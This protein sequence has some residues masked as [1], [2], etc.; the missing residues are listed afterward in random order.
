MEY[1]EQYFKRNANKKVMIIWMLMGVALSIS[2]GI[3]VKKGVRDIPYFVMFLAACWVPFAIGFINTR[4]KGMANESYKYISAIGY[5]FFYAFVML[6]TINPL[7]F[8][9]IF[10]FTTALM[11]YKDKKLMIGSGIANA[12]IIISSVVN[13]VVTGEATGDVFANILIQI[14][15]I[16]FCCVAYVMSTEH[17]L[18]SD[19][20][21]LHTVET[22]L[23]R[24]VETIE[25]VK[26]AS[27]SIVDGVTVVR[28]LADENRQSA[29][30]VVKSMN[31]LADNNEVLREQTESSLDMTRKINA[32]AENV[33]NLIEQMVQMME[34]S[35][36]QAKSSSKELLDV[37]GSTNEMA[38]LSVEVEN[39][40]KNFQDEFEMVKNET[41]TIEKITNQTNLLALNA[42]I[43]A[44]RAGEAGKGFAV[45]ADQIRDLSSGTKVSSASIMTALA[46]L[47][48]TSEKMTNA[49]TKT[50]ELIGIT[51]EKISNVNESVQNI[52]EETIKL[53]E[54]VSI[55][56]GAMQ[57]VEDSNKNMVGNMQKITNIMDE[58]TESITDA[59]ENTKVM[60]SKYQETSENI[61]V[62]ESVVGKLIEELGAG[63][64]MSVADVEE[65]M[66]LVL[67]QS[68]NNVV[69]QYKTSVVAVNEDSIVT[70]AI[71]EE[72]FKLSQTAMYA[73]EVVVHNNMYVWENVRTANVK[74]GGIKV[75]VEGHPKV[76][77]R[78]KYKRMPISNTCEISAR[79]G[80]NECRISGQMVNISA[81]GFAF[82]TK[83]SIIQCMKNGVVKL[84]VNN[85]SHITD[86]T[87]EGVI[88]RITDNDGEFILGCRMFEDDGN[89]E[90]YVEENYS[91]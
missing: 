81:G 1:N 34:I 29:N 48:E 50:I 26:V 7:T 8:A 16:L 82:K 68:E 13:M 53:G 24:V 2:Y 66:K 61:I 10:P 5:S 76:V 15:C 77:N 47:A 64:F 84:D 41:G 54:N 37:M 90:K 83:E 46:N 60:R 39:I 87:L 17:M 72:G 33:G 51:S 30:D 91:E 21:M 31:K 79:N 78:R 55:V 62:I 86:R 35:V 19:G 18:K 12:I 75:Y 6:T 67:I 85:F 49:I 73:L 20:W 23:G 36:E 32:Q 28:E 44:A 65:G 14:A 42:S 88:I 56:D 74:N 69:K 40:L 58:M 11:L 22:N 63:G 45:V 27:T 80:E 38:Q 4:I 3:Q 43:E 9:Y 57:E 89:I 59:S 52:T 25:T 71:V 70:D